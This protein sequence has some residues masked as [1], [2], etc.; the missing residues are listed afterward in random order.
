M[1]RQPQQLDGPSQV[2]AELG[3]E[4]YSTQAHILPMR[5]LGERGRRA[6][7]GV[8]VVGE[9]STEELTHHL[10]AG[11]PKQGA[12]QR[13]RTHHHRAAQLLGAGLKV[14]D[15]A[16]IIGMTPERL[17]KLSREDSTFKELVEQY[18]GRELME[19]QAA[20]A[21]LNQLSLDAMDVITDRL[22]EAPEDVT[23]EE[24]QKLAFAALD[25]TGHGPQTKHTEEVQYGVAPEVLDA[26]RDSHKAQ[27]ARVVRQV[28]PVIIEG[29]VEECQDT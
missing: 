28:S 9:L 23:M 6:T 19:T 21:R 8:Q 3:Q 1:P 22:R 25:R 2:D 7:A 26:L 29:E 14:I 18:R 16:Y 17:G 13:L 4:F 27:Q 15:V 12:L 10:T 5:T 24:L 11:S 20:I